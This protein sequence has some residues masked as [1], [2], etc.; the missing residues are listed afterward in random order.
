MK[1]AISLMMALAAAAASLC[2]AT[3]WQQ[4]YVGGGGFWKQ[5]I[6]LTITRGAGTFNPGMPYALVIGSGAGELPLT[7]IDMKSVRVLNSSGVEYF[8]NVTDARGREVRDGQLAAGQRIIIPV[9]I[10]SNA[11][12]ESYFIYYDNASAWL[13]PDYLKSSGV[14]E[15]N[16]DFEGDTAWKLIDAKITEEEGANGKK[17]AKLAAKDNNVNGPESTKLTFSPKKVYTFSFR[18]KAQVNAGTWWALIDHIDAKGNPAKSGSL[19][20]TSVLAVKTFTEGW[21]TFS[22]TFGVAGSGAKTVI[23]SNTAAV[24]ARFNFWNGDNRNDG[25]VCIDDVV[26]S[27]VKSTNAAGSTEGERP[28]TVSAG[29]SEKI[30]FTETGRTADWADRTLPYRVPVTVRN[31]GGDLNDV[32]VSANFTR[33]NVLMLG[34]IADNSLRV[35]GPD[36][37]T[38][39]H[40]VMNNELL[41]IATVPAATVANYYLYFATNG[42][43]GGTAMSYDELLTS[44]AN[45]V[46]NASFEAGADT[47]EGWSASSETKNVDGKIE[48]DK[49][50]PIKYE[51]VNEGRF[52]NKCVKMTAPESAPKQWCGWRQLITNVKPNTTYIYSGWVK[53]LNIKQGGV[54]LHGHFKNAEGRTVATFSTPSLGTVGTMEQGKTVT[55]AVWDRLVTTIKTPSDCAAIEVHLT[56]NAYGTVWHDGI[57]LAEGTPSVPGALE[58]V[59][60]KDDVAV[61]QVNPVTKVFKDSLPLTAAKDFRIASARNEKEGLQFAVRS[62]KDIVSLMVRIVPP[63]NKKGTKLTN[64]TVDRIDFV[65]VDFPMGYEGYTYAPYRRRIPTGIGSDGWEGIWPDP[66]LPLRKPFAQ[67]ANESQPFA[68]T[69]NVPKTAAAGDYAGSVIIEADG[70]AVR[71]MPLTVTVYDF[72]L[73]DVT[74]VGVI[75]DVRTGPGNRFGLAADAFNKAAYKALAERRASTHQIQPEPKFSW[76]NGVAKMDITEYDAMAKYCMDELKMTVMYFPNFFYAFGW[77]FPPKKI[78][79]LEPFSKE[80]ISAYQ[81]CLKLFWNYLKERGWQDRFSLYISD[82]PHFEWG[83]TKAMVIEQMKKL[84]TM[85]HEV[86][87]AIKIYSSTWKY[88]P[89]WDGYLNHWGIG[90]YGNFAIE[91]M[92]RR[93]KA[94]D[95]FWFTTD[96][97]L[98][99]DTPYNSI[100]RLYPYFC[101][102]YNVSSWEFWGSTWW[103]YNPFKYGWHPPLPHTFMVGQE[104]RDQR[105][106]NGDGYYLYPGW[107]VG[108]E[109]MLSCIRLEQVRD[110]VED[111]EYLRILETRI[112]NAKKKGK[113]TASALAALEKARALVSIPNKGPRHSTELVKDPDVIMNVR[114]EIAREITALGE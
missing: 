95:Y 41:F 1:H 78:F 62:K 14:E 102:K 94:G 100:E 108:E 91:D 22:T 98:C 47:A 81:Q 87:P 72:E 45:L 39:R 86:D 64:F 44:K 111:F 82:E 57:M 55:E 65:P 92:E 101:Y 4:P 114:A 89:E 113:K 32:I 75:L 105:Y 29:A 84:C 76:A 61:W 93:K 109:G 99:L 80:Y 77:G 85:I 59:S 67:K 51:Y 110:G 96:G 56:M 106:P 12:T 7:G 18:Y 63:A 17:C 3:A 58:G 74:H 16:C 37:K 25:E 31:F 70:K 27:E 35:V 107:L 42:V 26:I 69:F 71:T 103:T 21:K 2:A 53:A 24:G 49:N 73:P 34:R 28:F 8:F 40:S 43:K 90:F 52:G 104:P 20:H 88:C 60:M 10:A 36:G 15:W 33:V 54:Q 6:P 11:S 38:M 46:K 5:R 50:S 68:V 48:Y 13:L 79:N 66:M 97:T 30:A 83:E 23:P 9:E 19:G 112:G